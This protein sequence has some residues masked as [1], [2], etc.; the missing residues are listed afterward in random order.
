VV[1]ALSRRRHMQEY[2]VDLGD[3]SL[4]Y[5]I[6]LKRSICKASGV[7]QFYDFFGNLNSAI[8]G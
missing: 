8:P 6:A 2:I 1:I 7:L 5:A 3:N 4:Q